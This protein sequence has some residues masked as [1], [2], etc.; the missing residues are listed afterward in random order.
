MGF[1][2]FCYTHGGERTTLHDVVWDA[3]VA[4]T[5][6]ARFHVLQKQTHILSPLAL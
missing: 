3:F 5:K 2:V 6:N 4:I 1:H